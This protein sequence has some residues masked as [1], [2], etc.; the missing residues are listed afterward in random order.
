MNR[1]FRTAKISSGTGGGSNAWKITY[2]ADTS[3][4]TIGYGTMLY[5]GK[6]FSSNDLLSGSSPT[7]IGNDNTIFRSIGGLYV[8]LKIFN[9]LSLPDETTDSLK[10]KI[11]LAFDATA[12]SDINENAP[13][14]ENIV[15]AFVDG[16]TNEVFDLRPQFI[17][18]NFSFL[19]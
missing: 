7:G 13:L 2:S 3:T 1:L 10:L 6:F 9:P 19:V 11:D 17:V 12:P 14:V 15:L 16:T 8:Y 18:T 4:V 5:N